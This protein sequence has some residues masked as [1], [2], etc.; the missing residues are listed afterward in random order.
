M[1]EQEEE[2]SSGSFWQVVVAVI[3]FNIISRTL[4]SWFI[5]S[6]AVGIAA[7]AVALIS[8]RF[9]PHQ[10]VGFL[11][12]SLGSLL[13][14]LAYVGLIYGVGYPLRKQFG[15]VLTAGLMVF[16]LFISFRLIPGF[17]LGKKAKEGVWMWLAMSAGFG[18]LFA[19]FAYINPE[20]FWKP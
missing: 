20:G 13:V 1:T 3:L 10:K 2:R 17:F 7:F 6:V 9:S 11:K 14:I 5:E 19:F 12:W 18:L 8:Y 15:A 4:E 16:V